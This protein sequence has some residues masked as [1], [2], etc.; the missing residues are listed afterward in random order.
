[1]LSVAGSQV[2]R[3]VRP[4]TASGAY[5]TGRYGLVNWPVLTAVTTRSSV[6]TDSSPE[7]IRPVP[8]RRVSSRSS[9]DQE[10]PLKL[11]T[12]TE[13]RY[14]ADGEFVA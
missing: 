8:T 10:S 14:G 13:R 11:S 9:G 2:Q 4:L 1:M 7:S 12:V 6:A 5:G 3:P